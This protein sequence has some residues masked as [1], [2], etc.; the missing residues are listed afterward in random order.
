M[1]ERDK[2]TRKKIRHLRIRNKIS[3]TAAR[4]R[5]CV[6]RSANNIYAQLID[7][8][9]G[10][11]LASASSL[12]NEKGKAAGNKEAAKKV[13]QELGKKASELKIASASFD[14]A[15]YLYHGR[16]K[17]LADAARAEGLKF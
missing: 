15:G 1:S 6:F 13:G 2:N 16:V 8:E 4:P 9:K 14:R 5:L 11:T 7:D 12:K 3:G 17:E 10:V